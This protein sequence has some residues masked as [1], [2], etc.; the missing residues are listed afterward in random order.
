MIASKIFSEL[1]QLSKPSTQDFELSFL[2]GT[3]R[4]ELSIFESQAICA[5]LRQSNLERFID[6]YGEGENTNGE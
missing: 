5:L 6:I 3:G 4:Q 2:Q 1:Q